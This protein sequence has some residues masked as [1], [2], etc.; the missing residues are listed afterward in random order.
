MSHFQCSRFCFDKIQGRRASLRSH[1]P[2]ATLF[3]AFGALLAATRRITRWDVLVA[4]P[5]EFAK[6]ENEK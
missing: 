6:M 5:I 2:L 1:L 4:L 3:R